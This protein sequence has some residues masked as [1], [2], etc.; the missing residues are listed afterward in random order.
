MGTS[1]PGGGT[2]IAAA[3]SGQ[4]RPFAGSRLQ[5][6]FGEQTSFVDSGLSILRPACRQPGRPERA[7]ASRIAEVLRLAAFTVAVALRNRFKRAAR[8]C[9]LVLELTFGCGSRP[10]QASARLQQHRSVAALRALPGPP[11]TFEVRAVGEQ[12]YR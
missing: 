7:Q 6:V 10:R 9:L 4:H 8:F 11:P 3:L 5:A 1:A 2:V 12:L